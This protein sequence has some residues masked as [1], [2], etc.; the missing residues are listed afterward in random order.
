MG[1]GKRTGQGGGGGGEVTHKEFEQEIY[2]R[3]EGDTET[4]VSSKKY[5]DIEVEQGDIETL[6]L[7]N[8]YTDVQ[9]ENAKLSTQI[10]LPAVQTKADLPDPATLPAGNNY[11][12]RVLK[13]TTK[14]WRRIK[15]K[16]RGITD[17]DNNGVWQRIA[18]TVEWTYYGDN[19]DFI[20]EEELDDA[21][22]LK[23]DCLNRTVQIDLYNQTSITDTGGNIT[24][25][26]I[27]I[28]AVAN[29]GTGNDLGNIPGNSAT[30]DYAITSAT[31]NTSKHSDTSDY[32][33]HSDNS[34]TATTAGYATNS[35]HAT[36]SDSSGH[37]DTADS[38]TFANTANTAT[39]SDTSDYANTSANAISSNHATTSDSATHSDTSD[40]ADNSGHADTADNTIHCDTADTAIHSDT[41]DSATHSDT[42]DYATHSDTSDSAFQADIA[43]QAVKSDNAT[44]AISA[45]NST[46]S[47][48]T[49]KLAI[50]VKI[51][52][53][54]FDG[55]KDINVLGV[56]YPIGSIYM[57]IKTT[58][59]SVLTDL[60]TWSKINSNY[61]LIQSDSD[62]NL[63][64][65]N[66]G[67]VIS[68]RHTQASHYHSYN[69]S[70]N[71]NQSVLNSGSNQTVNKNSYSDTTTTATPI[72]NYTGGDIN[73]AAGL[74][75]NIWI[76]GS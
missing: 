26:V 27:G 32:A 3:K 39:Y 42:S 60:G 22:L 48:N 1:L 62:A 38:A 61:S 12:C 55:S 11:L 63:N 28:L 70:N 36:I 4:L 8:E 18:H 76:R 30:S 47:D 58:L 33:T 45:D 24:P 10:W 14:L 9:I 65:Y 16:I 13:D 74:K 15:N 59:P 40:Y 66:S 29:G 7:A 41:A 5:A 51:N 44:H 25:G 53:V 46:Y 35:T 69:A 20:D 2:D 52:G 72:I 17:Q 50:P 71:S 21:L 54:S 68:H 6:T 31:S 49:Y 34:D 73:R 64:T 56:L 57:S 19:L 37:A 23:Q 67:E 43:K 75:V